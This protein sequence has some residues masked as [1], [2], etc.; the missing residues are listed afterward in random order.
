[1]K[2]N[3]LIFC[4]YGQQ[5]PYNTMLRYHNWGKFLIKFGY[6]TTIVAASTVHNTDID[7]MKENEGKSE[8]IVDGV[9]YLYIKTPYYK[10]NGMSRIINM[11]TYAIKLRKSKRLVTNP[12]L[13]IFSGIYLFPFV[14]Y[15]FRKKPV[16]CDVPD[17]WP[18]SITEY[19]S[20]NKNNLFIK[21]LYYLEKK[22][23]IKSDAIIFSMEGGKNYLSEKK[24]SNNQLFKKTYHINMGIDL[25]NFD[26]ETNEES[27][28][29]KK[30]D[31]Y[32]VTYTGSIRLA[33]NIIAICEAAK[34]LKDNGFNKIQIHLYGNGPDEDI[35]KSYCQTN[36]LDN[37][38]FFG[39]FQKKDISKILKKS[40]VNIMT[41]KHTSL[42]KY[43][44]SQSKLFDYLAS[45]KP[46]IN[47]G[48][49]GYNLVSR[50]KCGIVVEEENAKNISDAIVAIHSLSDEE[51]KLMGERS[52]LA[53]ID[54]DQPRIVSQ[55]HD[56]IKTFV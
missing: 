23:Y 49:W 53:A 10:G 50:Y 30:S 32:I 27:F 19:T 51:V 7:V 12:D 6:N 31:E 24:Y 52:R 20:I 21:F 46:I 8:S 41:Y 2:K 40:N 17:L 55:L 45:G 54:Y 35:A 33:N 42:M 47:C 5:P 4:H 34:I 56:I 18:L 38:K 36:K 25:A 16:I 26:I 37:V 11:F 13:V 44:G 28:V 9:R 48:K 14:K 3:I 43:G 1:M 22:A 15:V 39:R 29:N